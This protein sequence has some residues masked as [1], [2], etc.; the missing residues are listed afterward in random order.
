[1]AKAARPDAGAETKAPARKALLHLDRRI[2]T[3]ILILAALVAGL[4]RMIVRTPGQVQLDGQLASGAYIG[5][6]LGGALMPWVIALIAAYGYWLWEKSRRTADYMRES[7]R[8]KQ[9][10]LMHRIVL[11]IV[12]LM[13][14]EACGM[15]AV[16]LGLI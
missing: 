6:V 1:M 14:V 12:L 7:F 10:R 9:R 13:V 3:A 2:W 5:G 15:A 4:L 16:R 8:P 11:F